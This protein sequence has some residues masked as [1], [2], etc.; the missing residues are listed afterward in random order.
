MDV[1]Q[2]QRAAGLRTLGRNLDATVPNWR[3]HAKDTALWNIDKG[4]ALTA[5]ELL[6]SEI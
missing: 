6:S 4:F 3:D 5:D 1:F 2:T